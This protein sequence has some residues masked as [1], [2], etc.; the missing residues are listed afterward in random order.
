MTPPYS[1]TF[2]G[3]GESFAP[4]HYEQL[5]AVSGVLTLGD[6]STDIDA[7]GLRDHSWG[8]RSWQA[9][10]FYR[11]LHGS[12]QGI[13]FM[14]AYFGDPDGA[15]R[16]GGFVWDGGQLQRCDEIEVSTDRDD[17]SQPESVTV[18]LRAEQ[19]HWVFRGETKSV[20]PLR[21]RRGDSESPA[22]ATR[23]AEAAMV[24][25]AEDGTTLHGMAEYLDQI[26]DGELAGLRI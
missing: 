9:P 6:T 22:D 4:N 24:W 13:G 23:I 21:H 11:W 8:P 10:H 17:Y 18:T 15:D 20:V 19:R 2:D 1:E 16:S 12:A 25:T 3:A 26:Y 5:M 14:G 7:Y